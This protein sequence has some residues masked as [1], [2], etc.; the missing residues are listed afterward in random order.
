MQKKNDWFDSTKNDYTFTINK[1]KRSS[2]STETTYLNI[3]SSAKIIISGINRASSSDQVK[4]KEDKKKPVV[5]HYFVQN[6]Q[7]IQ[8]GRKIFLFL[9]L[10]KNNN[11]CIIMFSCFSC[12]C[13]Y[14]R[15]ILAQNANKIWTTQV[16]FMKI[17]LFTI[18]FCC[19]LLVAFVDFKLVFY[20]V[21]S[22]SIWLFLQML[23]RIYMDRCEETLE[24]ERQIDS[25]LRLIVNWADFQVKFRY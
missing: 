9:F 3:T 13:F 20:F 24:S 22:S 10:F 5:Y 21:F 18:T 14:C 6:E 7:I 2:I 8:F 17:G 19:R 23:K 15:V 25:Q 1:K 11:V 4:G 16:D 12:K